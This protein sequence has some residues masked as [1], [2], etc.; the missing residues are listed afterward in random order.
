RPPPRHARAGGLHLRPALPGLVGPAPVP[1]PARLP[2][3]TRLRAARRRRPG[4]GQP[5]P[6]GRDGADDLARA[7]YPRPPR[8]AREASGLGAPAHWM[9]APPAAHEGP[10][11]RPLAGPARALD[12][13]HR[14]DLLPA[15]ALPVLPGATPRQANAVPAPRPRSQTAGAGR[16]GGIA[17]Q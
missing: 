6:P 17:G 11:R 16:G 9:R 10:G 8:R 3:P 14:A 4:P 13:R 12:R 7:R 5:Q 15:T 1:A 2:P